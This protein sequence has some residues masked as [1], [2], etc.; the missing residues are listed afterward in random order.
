MTGATAMAV[1]PDGRIFVCEQ[2]GAL[3]VIKGGHLLA[4]P[5][6]RVEVDSQWERGLIGVALDPDFAANGFVYVGYVG[7]ALP[8]SPHQPVHRAGDVAAPDSELVFFEGDDQTKWGAIPA[9]H[10]GGAIHFGAT[11]SFTS[12]SASKPPASPRKSWRR[13]LGKLLRINRDG[14][15]PD[16]NPFY[17]KAKGKYRA[18]WAS[19]AAQ[20]VYFCGSARHG[21][22]LHQRRGRSPLGRINEGFA[23]A[24]YGW[25]AAEGPTTDPQFRGPIHHYPVASVSGGAFWP[26]EATGAFPEKYPRKVLLHGF[27]QGLDQDPRPGPPGAGRDIRE[28]A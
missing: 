18:I 11:A 20:P 7:P 15:I 23:G 21:P 14:T 1:A 16:D 28:R 24:N 13:C 5:L 2:T 9:G 19:R 26:V 12:R 8:A 4:E 3:R 6:L 22:D 10:Q 17:S 27:R 25:P